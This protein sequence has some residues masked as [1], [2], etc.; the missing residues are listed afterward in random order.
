[1]KETKKK[2]IQKIEMCMN[3]PFA[4]AMWRCACYLNPVTRCSDV[5]TQT[6]STNK[7]LGSRQRE[8]ESQANLRCVPIRYTLVL[9]LYIFS[10]C[11]D[12]TNV[13]ASH[14]CAEQINHKANLAVSGLNFS[15]QEN[16]ET[17]D[18]RGDFSW[19]SIVKIFY[20]SFE[21]NNSATWNITRS[22]EPN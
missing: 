12:A 4:R 20:P 18:D 10:C 7:Y 13:S 22:H 6:T 1:M 14:I 15:R 8:R 19:L 17:I 11:F 16:V 2:K 3:L 9:D 21:P 5:H